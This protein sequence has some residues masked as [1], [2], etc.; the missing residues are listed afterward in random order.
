MHIKELHNFLCILCFWVN[1]YQVS[2]SAGRYG[3]NLVACPSGS[4]T[5]VSVPVQRGPVYFQS[6]VNAIHRGTESISI[7][8]LLP[9]TWGSQALASS[10]YVRWLSGQ[11]AGRWYPVL[12]NSAQ[13]ITISVAGENS[14][15]FADVDSFALVPYWTLDQLFPPSSQKTIHVSQGTLPHQH[16]TLLLLQ[17]NALPGVNRPASAVL[18][19]TPTGWMTAGPASSPAGSTLLRPGATFVVRHPPGVSATSFAPCGKVVAGSDVVR[20]TPDPAGKK[21][22]HVSV[23]RVVP[24]AL[25]QAGLGAEVFSSSPNH[26]AASRLDELQI[27]DNTATSFN[28]AASARYYKVGTSWHRDEGLGASNPRAE[29]DTVLAPASGVV[30]RKAAAS[31][32][33]FW[34]NP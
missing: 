3:Y 14:Q 13:S 32:M 28:K 24:I 6:K 8:P 30:I 1:G 21:D 18:I 15:S 2:A 29:G 22:F 27:F 16:R 25:G 9:P 20:I 19:L 12:S 4:D 26:A 11:N 7:V 33:Q 34:L 31:G 23:Q 17:D 5:V 10:H